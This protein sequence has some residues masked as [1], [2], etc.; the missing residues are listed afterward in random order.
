M[1]DI[2]PEGFSLAAAP[3][4]DGFPPIQK[5]LAAECFC[6][7]ALSLDHLIGSREHVRRNCQV[8]LLRSL[9][10]IT[11]SNVALMLGFLHYCV[12]LITL[13]ARA[14]T[15]GG[16]VRPICFAV[17]RLITSSNFVGCSTGRSAGL[18]PL[19]ILST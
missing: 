10:I 5:Q 2:L 17:F 16:I 11:N 4:Q 15:F 3:R 1:I 14:S 7:D 18:A 9:L 6:A 12:H 13:S 8:D 19:R